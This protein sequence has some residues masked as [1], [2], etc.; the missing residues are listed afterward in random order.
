MSRCY[1]SDKVCR[2][3][4]KDLSSDLRE[5]SVA[6]SVHLG[7]RLQYTSLSGSYNHQHRVSTSNLLDDLYKLK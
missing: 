3:E 5:S 4:K 6:K 7:K 2:I 1:E